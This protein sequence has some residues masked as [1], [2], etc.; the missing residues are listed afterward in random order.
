MHTINNKLIYKCIIYNLSIYLNFIQPF[1]E[2]KM[3]WG[4]QLYTYTQASKGT[5]THGDCF[6]SPEN[7]SLDLSISSWIGFCIQSSSQEVG[8]NLSLHMR[9]QAEWKQ[10][11]ANTSHAY[12]TGT[13]LHHLHNPSAH[14]KATRWRCS[15]RWGRRSGLLHIS[16]H[17]RLRQSEKKRVWLWRA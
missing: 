6:L 4:I 2:L 17:G 12:H 11:E 16:A 14:H 15:S 5:G 9:N 3:L 8:R 13:H 1:G 7:A 10:W